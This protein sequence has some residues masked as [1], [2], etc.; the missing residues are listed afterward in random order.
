VH[1]G[2]V[3]FDDSTQVYVVQVSMPVKEREQVICAITFGVNL[4]KL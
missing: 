1:I 3:E 4:D 2:D